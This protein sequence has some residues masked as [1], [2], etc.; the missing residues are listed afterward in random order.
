MTVAD[1]YDEKAELLK[2]IER[3]DKV[4][5]NLLDLIEGE[6]DKPAASDSQKGR[7]YGQV[8]NWLKMRKSLIPS[9][10]GG[11]LK[12]IGHGLKG[13]ERNGSGGRGP[14][15]PKGTSKDG[16]GILALAK[17][18]RAIHERNVESEDA[19][20]DSGNPENPISPDDSVAGSSGLAGLNG[21]E[22]LAG[23]AN[24]AGNGGTV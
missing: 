6:E 16:R 8:Q 19:G 20:G 23:N 21:V 12:E 3:M 10:Q 9:E 15:R 17:K 11:R 14:G 2:M 13:G 22:P 18:V 4:A 7:L 1:E 5:N 24:V